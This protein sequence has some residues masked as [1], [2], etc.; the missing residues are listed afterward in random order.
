M[1]QRKEYALARDSDAN[2]ATHST[3]KASLLSLQILS[4]LKEYRAPDSALFWVPVDLN[5]VRGYREKIS[6]PIDL[7]TIASEVFADKYGADLELFKKRV[8]L[9]WDNCKKFNAGRTLAHFAAEYVV[10]INRI[11]VLALNYTCL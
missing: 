6:T 1:I 2:S 4:R 5:S 9:V 11:I 3:L 10:R 8:T 7:G